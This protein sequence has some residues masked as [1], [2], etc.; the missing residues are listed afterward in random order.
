MQMEVQVAHPARRHV[1]QRFG[2]TELS[3]LGSD[4]DIAVMGD[5]S[6]ASDAVTIDGGDSRLPDILRAE[7]RYP[8]GTR[9]LHLRWCQQVSA[10]AERPA[11]SACDYCHARLLVSLICLPGILEV[12]H[13]VEGE[14]IC[15]LCAVDSDNPDSAVFLL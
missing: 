3:I 11:A 8:E 10:S 7:G 5:E 1:P 13:H 12:I 6:A 15:S 2:Y 14:R 9:P 4:A